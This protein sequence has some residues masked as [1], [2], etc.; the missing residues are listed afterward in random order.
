MAAKRTIPAWQFSNSSACG[1]TSRDPR[2]QVLASEIVRLV[3]LSTSLATHSARNERIR[4]R[5]PPAEEASRAGM[6]AHPEEIIWRTG[7]CSLGGLDTR[8]SQQSPI[9]R[10]SAPTTAT[11]SRCSFSLSGSDTRS[12]ERC[13]VCLQRDR[14]WTEEE[15]RSD[16]PAHPAAALLPWFTRGGN[17]PATR[18]VTPAVSCSPVQRLPAFML[19]RRPS[20]GPPSSCRTC[21]ADLK[22][23][24]R[25]PGGP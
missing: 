10:D 3:T 20:G 21:S 23:A 18:R 5:C 11:R 13:A 9:D 22:K 24:R 25:D 16:S 12:E 7:A 19:C 1:R 2:V 14:E 8:L 15:D 4:A 6:S 17:V